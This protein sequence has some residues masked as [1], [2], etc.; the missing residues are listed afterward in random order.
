ML[1]CLD[2]C[3]YLVFTNWTK[4]TRDDEERENVETQQMKCEM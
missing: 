4:H 1:S 2:F 3:G